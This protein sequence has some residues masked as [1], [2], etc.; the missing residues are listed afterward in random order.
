MKDII[1][2]IGHGKCASTTLQHKVFINEPGYLG[3]A[4]GMKYNFAKKLQRISPVGPSITYSKSET[5]QW[6]KEVINYAD[7]HFPAAKNLIVSSEMYSNRNKFEERPIISFL[8]Y[9]SENVWTEGD[10]KVVMV[11]RNQFDKIASGYAQLSYYNMKASQD[12]FEKQVKALINKNDYHLM[13]DKW[14]KQLNKALGKKNVCVLLMED[15]VTENFWFQ[16]KNFCQL[17]NFEVKSMFTKDSNLNSRKTSQNEWS[18]REFNPEMKAKVMVN[19]YFGLLWPSSLLPG[20]RNSTQLKIKQYLNQHY[21]KKT[22]AFKK[23][24]NQK[25]ELTEEL[26]AQL[27]D[28]YKSSNIELG[29]LLDRDLSELGYY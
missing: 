23:N 21:S 20:L 11:I 12:N 25:I 3:T 2:H 26:K 19:N 9:F 13:Y 17:D 5:R 22:K 14:I 24:A 29:K 27:L 8:E 15:I 28:Y 10:V 18:L 4:K 7:Q 1:F 6:A 16:L